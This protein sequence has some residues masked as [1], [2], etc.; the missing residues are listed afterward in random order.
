MNQGEKIKKKQWLVY[1]IGKEIQMNKDMAKEIIKKKNMRG[2]LQ[3][4]LQQIKVRII[5]I[6]K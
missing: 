2:E 1:F 3:I 5:K 4:I 6:K